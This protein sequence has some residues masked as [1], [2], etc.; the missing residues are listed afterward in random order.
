MIKFQKPS[1]TFAEL[2]RLASVAFSVSN[3]P[4]H[5]AFDLNSVLPCGDPF[6]EDT[7]FRVESWKEVDRIEKRIWGGCITLFQRLPVSPHFD[8]S[9]S[10]VG[11][12]GRWPRQLKTSARMVTTSTPVKLNGNHVGVLNLKVGN[13]V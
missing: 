6:Q 2:E 4:D 7:G 5:R 9:C 8:L 1:L 13:K 10:C 3:P 11:S 12:R